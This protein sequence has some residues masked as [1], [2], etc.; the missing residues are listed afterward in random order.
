MSDLRVI[1]Q[2]P[3]SSLRVVT[4]DDLCETAQPVITGSLDKEEEWTKEY[5]YDRSVYHAISIPGT[6][7]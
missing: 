4:P 5:S 3:R 2:A 7:P 6:V 1:Q